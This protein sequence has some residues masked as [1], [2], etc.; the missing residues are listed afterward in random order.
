M[1]QLYNTFDKENHLLPLFDKKIFTD[2]HDWEFGWALLQPINIAKNAEDDK[3]LTQ[4]F[5]PGQK[6]LYFIW[7]LDG[8]VTNGGFIQFYNNNYRKYL[9]PI[10]EGLKLIGDS[11]MLVLI[12]KVDKEYISHKDIFIEKKDAETLYEILPQFDEYDAVY[13][14]IHDNTMKLIEKYARDNYKEFVR[15]Q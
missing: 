6:A 3:T 13:F 14:S 4:R 10:I 9:P 7:Y 1:E 5:S 2:L 12:E 8:Q 15:F 11:E